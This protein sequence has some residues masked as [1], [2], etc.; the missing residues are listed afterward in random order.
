MTLLLSAS[1]L[2]RYATCARAYAW[3]YRYHYPEPGGGG[4]RQKLG[5]SLHA[6][7]QHFWLDWLDRRGDRSLEHLERLWLRESVELDETD[8]KSGW[9]ALAGYY[10]REVELQTPP[11]PFAT[12]GRIR[13]S[14]NL[15][16]VDVQFESR[17]D[18]LLWGTAPGASDAQLDLVE[19]KTA[20]QVRTL[21]QL[22]ADL[23]LSC[24]ILGLRA[25]YGQSL[26]SVSHYYLLS[27][28][29]LTFKV[30]PHHQ[31]YALETTRKLVGHLLAQRDWEPEPG[32]H[33]KRCGYRPQCDLSS[34]NQLPPSESGYA[35]PEEP[36]VL[37][38]F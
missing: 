17:Y 7:L 2:V 22:E 27:G 14:L 11:R 15:E 32:S 24:Y 12:E 13:H 29:K 30:L 26:R 37:T 8:R 31:A 3:K 33:C 28:E 6:A 10:R 16:R 38:L 1:R 21:S 36:L 19:F 4:K 25:L 35:R 20:R 23:Q 9:F 5:L 34:R 18:L